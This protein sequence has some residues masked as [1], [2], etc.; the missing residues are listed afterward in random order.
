MH[1]KPPEQFQP[2]LF[3]IISS[4]SPSP[5]SFNLLKI[6]GEYQVMLR[7][8]LSWR[9][10][11]LLFGCLCILSSAS[12]TQAQ[13]SFRRALDFDGDG[14]TDFA[15]YRYPRDGGFPAPTTYHILQS[16]DGATRSRQFG[17]TSGDK[18]ATGDYDGDG[19]ADLTLYR[20]GAV[21]GSPSYFYI[22][23][24]SDNALQTVQWGMRGD[25]PVSR[26]YDGDGRTD[27]AVYRPGWGMYDPS[28]WYIL[29]SSTGQLRAVQ[30]GLGLSSNYGDTPVSGDYDGDGKADIAVYRFD[31]TDNVRTDTNTFYVLRSSDEMLIVKPWGN[32]RTDTILPGDYDGDGATDFC[33]VRAGTVTGAPRTWYIQYSSTGEIKVQHWGLTGNSDQIVSGDYDGDGKSDLAIWREGNGPGVSSYY[34]VL[35][36]SDGGLLMQHWG[37]NGDYPLVVWG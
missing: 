31:L 8:I 36:S 24:S 12:T 10:F 11:A 13:A 4:K 17:F 32:Q 1:A 15:V 34:Y 5:N 35:K 6:L 22:L 7:T 29:Q 23:R 19:R 37:V 20:N 28:Y 26:D 30:W 3:E 9:S 2:T 16:G 14:K 18:H 21:D 25:R 27:I 33:A